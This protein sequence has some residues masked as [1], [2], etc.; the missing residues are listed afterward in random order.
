MPSHPQNSMQPG[1]GLSCLEM[2]KETFVSWLH[3][4]FLLLELVPDKTVS[5]SQFSRE[6]CTP[7]EWVWWGSSPKNVHTKQGQGPGPHRSWERPRSCQVDEAPGISRNKNERHVGGSV[8][9]V[10]AFGSGHDLRSWDWAPH[11]APCSVALPVAP[12]ACALS[13]SLK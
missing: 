9:W 11:Q 2:Q 6:L 8:V 13:L 1:T 3:N 7:R 5:L 12:A 4:P 10:S